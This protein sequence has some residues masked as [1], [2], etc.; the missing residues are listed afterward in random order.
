MYNLNMVEYDRKVE[1]A[2]ASDSL[3][4][5][6]WAKVLVMPENINNTKKPL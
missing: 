2:H 4:M 5:A 1:A 6:E 3:W